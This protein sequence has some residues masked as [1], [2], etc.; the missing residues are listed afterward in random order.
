MYKQERS[1]YTLIIQDIFMKKGYV[2]VYTGEGKGKTTAALG[3]CVRAAGAGFKV[4]VA[5]FIKMGDYSEIKALKRFDDLITVKQ[6][7]L[8]RFIKGKPAQEDIDTA[9]AGLK[10]AKAALVSGEYDL[11]VLEEG[12]VAVTCG[13]FSIDDLMKV[14]ELRPPTTEL[15]ITGRGAH[16]R[17]IEAADLVTEM[18]EIKHYYKQGVQARIGIEK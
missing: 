14:V 18:R 5:Q 11:V 2:Q 12:N 7:G 8:G 10:E 6:Y 15:L 17:L 3:L 1:G 4:Y 13:L 9:Q 16:E